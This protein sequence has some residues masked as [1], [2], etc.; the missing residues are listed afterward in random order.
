MNEKNFLIIVKYI[1][2][3]DRWVVDIDS[4]HLLLQPLVPGE[5]ASAFAHVQELAVARIT[6]LATRSDRPSMIIPAPPTDILEDL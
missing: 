3:L 2:E 1:P 6:P 4:Q 5:E